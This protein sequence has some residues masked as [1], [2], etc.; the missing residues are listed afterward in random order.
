MLNKKTLC[1]I[2]YAIALV[3]AITSCFGILN[4][5]LN[6]VPF[7]DLSIKNTYSFK[8]EDF[9]IPFYFYLIAFVICAFAVTMIVLYISGILKHDRLGLLN[10]CIIAS[11]A[12]LLV[13]PFVF[14]YVLFNDR[15]SLE[16]FQYLMS[17]TLRSGIMSFISS[18]G[19]ILF[20][21][22]I[23]VKLFA[24]DTSNTRQDKA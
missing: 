5:L 9:W 21:N 24:P 6:L 8:A 10:C 1:H 22:L 14:V 15:A 2:V 18:T 4:E 19:I 7:Y 16:Y 3:G 13:L 12:I 11:C 23:G 20:C 17:Y